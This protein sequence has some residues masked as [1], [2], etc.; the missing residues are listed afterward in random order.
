[1]V[2]TYAAIISIT[3]IIIIMYPHLCRLS[4]QT[5]SYKSTKADAYFLRKRISQDQE[6]DPYCCLSSFLMKGI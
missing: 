5:K 4:L 1:M 3:N 2:V 6:Q